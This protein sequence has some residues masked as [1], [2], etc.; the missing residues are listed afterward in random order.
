MTYNPLIEFKNIWIE[1]VLFG[2]SESRRHRVINVELTH[3]QTSTLNFK[4]LYLYKSG[5]MKGREG[6]K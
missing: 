4:N 1:M 5:K 6:I 3:C 2:E